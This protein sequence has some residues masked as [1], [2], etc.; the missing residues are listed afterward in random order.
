MYTVRSLLISFNLSFQLASFNSS[1]SIHL[2]QLI[3]L[4]SSLVTRLFQLVSFSSSLFQQLAQ[5]LKHFKDL[6]GCHILPLDE[7]CA[8]L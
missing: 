6:H 3:F 2:F 5:T 1:L 4:N 7:L 8:C